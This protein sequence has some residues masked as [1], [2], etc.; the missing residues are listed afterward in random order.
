MGTIVAVCGFDEFEHIWALAIHIRS[1]TGKEHPNFLLIPTTQFD[2]PNPGTLNCYYKLGCEVDTL[3]PSEWWVTPEIIR[4]KTEWADIIWVPGGNLKY[5][6]N[7]WKKT[8]VAEAVKQAYD[9][10]AVVCGGSAGAMIWFRSGFDNCAVYDEKEFTPGLG[11]YPYVIC[12]HYECEGW[13]CFNEEVKNQPLPGFAIEDG[14]AL[15]VPPN[16]DAYVFRAEGTEKVWFFDPAAG[17]EK[18]EFTGGKLI[19]PRTS[20][21]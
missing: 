20:E 2:I 18:T 17:F 16:G 21:T 15:C 6:R 13:Q 8:G 19:R 4:Q 3:K 10:G 11:F 1:L 12:P 5:C 9:R 7:T 14:A